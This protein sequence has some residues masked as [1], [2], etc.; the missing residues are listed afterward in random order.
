MNQFTS[1]GSFEHLSAL[2]ARRYS[3]RSFLPGA[4]DFALV[5]QI[6]THAQSSVSWSITQPSQIRIVSGQVLETVRGEMFARAQTSARAAPELD[7]PRE[8]R[9]V[10]K[11]R[12]RECG[13]G[14]Y[15]AIGIA[16]GDREAS[17]RQAQENFRFF[18]APHVALLTT[19]EALGTHGVMDCGAWVQGFLLACA[20]ADVDCVAQAAVAAWP[21]IWRKHISLPEEQRIICGVA[22]GHADPDAPANRF[23][24]TR[25]PIDEVVIWID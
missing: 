13:W 20:A 9:G 16:K 12:R 14:L 7:W 4:L 1:P 22:F 6:V 8:I 10:H 5:R 19:D 23:R 25:A 2:L 17:A 18:G 11:D 15:N 21:D 3:C 24:A